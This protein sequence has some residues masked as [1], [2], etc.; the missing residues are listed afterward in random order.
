MNGIPITKNSNR[1]LK[2]KPGKSVSGFFYSSMNF[3]FCA[4]RFYNGKTNKQYSG[5]AA[6]CR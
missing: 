2:S 6:N 5:M 3:Y 1:K 4:I